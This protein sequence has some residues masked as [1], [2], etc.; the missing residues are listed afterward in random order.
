MDCPASYLKFPMSNFT[1]L[2]HNMKFLESW[3]NGFMELHDTFMTIN[4]KALT[5]YHYETEFY[6]IPA[7][8]TIRKHA[9]IT[10][11]PYSFLNSPTLY[12][13]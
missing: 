1:S 12:W 10:M 2:K 3:G 9:N 7:V 5:L 8:E 4:F 6:M 13:F 11:L